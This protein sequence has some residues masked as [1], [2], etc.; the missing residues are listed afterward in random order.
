[1][2]IA[3]TAIL[4]FYLACLSCTY[5]PMIVHSE[6]EQLKYSLLIICVY[7]QTSK[8]QGYSQNYEQRLIFSLVLKNTILLH[9]PGIDYTIRLLR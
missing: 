6:W 2:P 7:F 3:Q 9:N 1:M 5:D 4:P 8:M